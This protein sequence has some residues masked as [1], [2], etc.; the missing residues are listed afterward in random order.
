MNNK[1]PKAGRTKKTQEASSLAAA[2]PVIRSPVLARV[3]SPISRA[4]KNYSGVAA[5]FP[6]CGTGGTRRKKTI[7]S[8]E[9]GVAHFQVYLDKKNLGKL[10]DLDVS[11]LADKAVWSEFAGYLASCGHY[12]N[13]TEMLLSLQSAESIYSGL[14]NALAQRF[15]G[16]EMFKPSPNAEVAAFHLSVKKD[17][18]S[19]ITNRNTE[20]Q[21]RDVEKSPKIGPNIHTEMGKGFLKANTTEGVQRHAAILSIRQAVGRSGEISKATW[22]LMKWDHEGDKGDIDWA[23]LKI[24]R[25]TTL[26]L[27]NDLRSPFLDWYT[28]IGLYL[29]VGAGV[30]ALRYHPHAKEK[31]YMFPWLAV[32]SNE[33]TRT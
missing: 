6:L 1:S 20:L 5:S 16:E 14:K 10:E 33:G 21:R 11:A 25:V 9:N 3:A 15:P 22:S 29:V 24:S 19:Q 12:L 13:N 4:G 26:P 7:D 8:R 23:R 18:R 30:Q 31:H 32:M 17:M 2:A 27:Y 28:A